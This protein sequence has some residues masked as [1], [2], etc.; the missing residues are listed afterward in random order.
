MNIVATLNEE[1][2]NQSFPNNQNQTLLLNQYKAVAENYARLEN[3]IAV[4]SDLTSNKSYIYYGK[5]ANKLGIA[6]NDCTKEINTIW[7]EDIFERIHPDDLMGKHLLEL[8][9]F[10]LLKKLPE[11]ERS[12]YHVNSYMRIKDKERNYLTIH[13][14]MFYVCSLSSGSLWLSLCLYNVSYESS[15]TENIYGIIVNSAS[16]EVIQ[17]DVQQCNNILSTREKEILKLIDKGKMSKEIADILFISKNTV[18]RHRQNILE[19][20]RVEIQ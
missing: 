6:D 7:E 18:D 11:K 1:L 12:D 9:F 8:Q 19:K 15:D 13:H 3:A 2:L 4:L 20:L 16:G 10:N 14:R 5:V 17:A